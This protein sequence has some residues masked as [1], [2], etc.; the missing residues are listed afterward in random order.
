MLANP[1]QSFLQDRLQLRLPEAEDALAVRLPVDVTGLD[2]WRVGDRL[3]TTL[4]EDGDPDRWQR[5]EEAV[6]T[7][8]PG[9]LGREKAARSSPRAPPCATRPGRLASVRLLPRQ[10]EP[11]D[12]T[13]P[14]APGSW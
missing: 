7:L 3:L 2:Q 10:S 12:V 6:G 14:T 8:P 4:L 13:L 9:R 11:V 1:V 5:L